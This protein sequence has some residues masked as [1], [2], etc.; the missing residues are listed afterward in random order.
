ML[1]AAELC[2]LFETALS[3]GWGYIWNGAGQT[4]TKA[5][6]EAATRAQTVRYGAQWIGK[7]VADCSGLFVWAYREKGA[8][9]YHGSN[10]IWKKHLSAKG[11]VKNGKKEDGTEL[12]PGTAVFLHRKAD[13]CRHHIGLYIGVG[14]VIEAKGT[15]YGVVTSNISKWDEWGELSAVIYREGDESK[16]DTVRKGCK[17]ED[18]L[19]MQNCLKARG[20]KCEAD[21]AFGAETLAE[22]KAF[23]TEAGLSADGV[24]GPLTWAALTKDDA[25]ESEEKSVDGRVAEVRLKI[26]ELE[27]QAKN[28]NEGIQQ[29]KDMLEEIEN[30][31]DVR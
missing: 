8:Y 10:T 12:L 1:K 23:Q 21:G 4:W 3:E 29:A 28:L 18:V 24:C 15:K 11:K 26:E 22:L 16:M 31:N 7:R 30:G 5:K 2:T 20:Y 9:I 17:G 14:V 27:A 6:Q 13:D 19:R 25:E